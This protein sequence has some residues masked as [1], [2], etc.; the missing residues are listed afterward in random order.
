MDE[1][2]ITHISLGQLRA[3]PMN[4]N[5]MGEAMLAKL[6]A[7]IERTGW[8]PPLV[9]RAW[10]RLEA[11]GLGPEGPEHP[12]AADPAALRPHASS[13]KPLYQVLDGHH[14]WAA[15]ERLGHERAACVVWE[16][17]DEEALVLL[18]TLN[19]LEGRD[20]PRKRAAVIERLHERLGRSAAELAR[21]LPESGPQ[22]RRHLALRQRMPTPVPPRPLADMPV[23]VHFFLT[24]EQKRRLDAALRHL[25]GTREEALMRMAEERLEI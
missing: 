18:A 16:A 17:D 25:G 24:G 13:P 1:Q 4:S 23:A 12:D 8:Y 2:A 21:L 5:A 11:C 22:V 9:V 15:L 3:H 6:A 10:E 20:D 19:R 14:R 7:H